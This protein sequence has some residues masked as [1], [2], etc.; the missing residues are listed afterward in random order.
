MDWIPSRSR[1]PIQQTQLASR[2]INPKRTDFTKIAVNGIEKL[3]FAIESQK[4]R[5]HEI[6]HK[7]HVHPPAEIWR[8]PVDID[9][10]S[11]AAAFLRRSAPYVGEDGSRVRRGAAPTPCTSDGAK[12]RGIRIRTAGASSNEF[13]FAR[14]A[15]FQRRF[16]ESGSQDS[17]SRK[18]PKFSL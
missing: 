13:E 8:D 3:A 2:H 11:M 7:L 9:S 16:L 17:G 15:I 1:L 12:F 5:I 4:R 10:F 18:K 6:L 14:H